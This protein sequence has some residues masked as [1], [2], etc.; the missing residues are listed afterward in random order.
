VIFSFSDT[1]TS[2]FP[3]GTGVPSS[4]PTGAPGSGG[5]IYVCYPADPSALPVPYPSTPSSATLSAIPS[6]PVPTSAPADS[7]SVPPSPT[8]APSD[9]TS[10]QGG[11]VYICRPADPSA[12]PAPIPGTSTM[13]VPSDPVP[14][15]DAPSVSAPDST[16]GVPPSMPT[17]K[18]GA[19][20]PDYVCY[21]VDPA[22]VPTP[23]PS[24]MT[25]SDPAPTS[26]SA[27][28]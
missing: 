12:P 23:L 5:Q 10:G 19:G 24:T 13:P 28:Q 22:S 9:P 25:T 14:T 27:S 15:S 21:P 20:G 3:S 4:V 8:S 17:D 6:D 7:T 2:A 1:P 18:H 26:I 16:A 11:P